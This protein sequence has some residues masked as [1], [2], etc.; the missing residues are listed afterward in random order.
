MQ[1]YVRRVAVNLWRGIIAVS[2]WILAATRLI[3]LSFDDKNILVY[4]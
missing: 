4:F 2:K 1:M 3:N